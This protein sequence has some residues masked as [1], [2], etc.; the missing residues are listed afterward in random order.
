MPKKLAREEFIERATSVHSNRYA[1]HKTQFR[2]GKDKVIITCP[3]HGDFIQQVNSHLQGHGCP[4]CAVLENS[5]IRTYT[6]DEFVN[7]SNLIHQGRYN[8][9]KVKYRDSKTPVVIICSKHGEFK[10]RPNDHL[11]GIG[12][13]LCG[14]EN[15]KS[16]IFGVGVNDC[17]EAV[18]DGMAYRIWRSMLSR[19]YSPSQIKKSPSYIGCSVC[20]EWHTFSNFKK[21]FENPENGYRD[22]YHLDKDILVKGNKIYSP[23]TCCFVP[24]EINALLISRK[25]DRG[26]YPIGV[27]SHYKK[28]YAYCSEYG[29]RIRLKELY[30]TPE[31]AFMAYK[32]EK[33]AYIKEIAAKYYSDGKI[34]KRVY[35]SLM[36]YNVEITD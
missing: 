35:D 29:K 34:T 31:E 3:I 4:E 15:K 25:R 33:E 6:Q 20:D 7:R 18:R 10:Q 16:L 30:D 8:Y 13:P 2:I 32:H 27:V 5:K 22:G 23:E 9:D 21:W 26:A 12:C 28:F 24:R 36:F 1:Y 14:V 17:G 19:V 11:R